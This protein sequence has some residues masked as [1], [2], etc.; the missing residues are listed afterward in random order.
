EA[1]ASSNE[2][3]AAVSRLRA[4]VDAVLPAPDS[5]RKEG[6]LEAAIRLLETD[7]FLSRVAAEQIATY[8]GEA[9]RSL[10]LVPTMDKIALERFFDEAGG[11][12]LVLHAQVG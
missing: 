12:L 6:E 4:A 8:L 5:A 2:M 1:P 11:I 10:G 9:K 7:Y 3:S